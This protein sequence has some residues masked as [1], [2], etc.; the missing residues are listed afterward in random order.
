MN[1]SIHK[2]IYSRLLRRFGKVMFVYTGILFLLA[3]TGYVICRQ[4]IWY[5]Y[6][7]L[8]PLIHWLNEHILSSVLAGLLFG[9][10]VIAC[11]QFYAITRL[12]LKVTEAVDIVCR[13]EDELVVLPEMLKE[14]EVQLNSILSDV[15]SS[16]YEAKLAEQ[17]KN[18]MIMYMAHDLK[19][20]LTSVLGYLAILREDQE[21]PEETRKKYLS[22]IFD[23]ASRLEELINEFFEV[24]R[25]NFSHI[26][27]E[28][29]RV[30][31]SRMV[32][33]I[34]YE[35]GP[36]FLEK[37]L[38]ADVRVQ[39]EL[40]IRC[41]V[42]QMERVFDNLLRNIFSYSYPDTAVSVSVMPDEHAA[43]KITVSNHGMTIP[44]EKCEHIFDPFYR[45]DSARDSKTGGAGLGLAIVREIVERHKGTITCESENEQICFTILLPSGDELE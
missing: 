33:Q 15:K 17:Q 14:I 26:Q 37:Q 18:D 3:L 40:Y 36:I 38:R 35:F 25:Y 13:G 2:D 1:G 34:V 5:G 45:I 16:R 10:L 41:D 6:E 44:K 39:P 27:L 30:N 4:K 9:G 42:N 24:T 22:I 23:K 21:I 8:Y 20:P 32:E 29:T 11:Y 28:L 12:L 19:I 7:S 31:I 43:V